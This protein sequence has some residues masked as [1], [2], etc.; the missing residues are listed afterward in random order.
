MSEWVTFQFPWLLPS[1]FKIELGLCLTSRPWL[2]S[3]GRTR[4]TTKG[5]I[6]AWPFKL[7]FGCLLPIVSGVAHEYYDGSSLYDWRMANAYIRIVSTAALTGSTQSCFE[8]YYIPLTMSIWLRLLMWCWCI[9]MDVSC[10]IQFPFP[11]EE[12]PNYFILVVCFS[13]TF[14]S[15]MLLLWLKSKYV[16][17]TEEV[18]LFV[19]QPDP[20]HVIHTDSYKATNSGNMI[21]WATYQAT[22]FHNSKDRSMFHHWNRSSHS[23]LSDLLGVYIFPTWP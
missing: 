5:L 18:F 14:S 22:R 4:L 16:L 21:P 11:T 9:A 10:A 7:V 2:P 6:Y 3:D 13:Q 23:F 17:R 20:W 19:S 1:V 12:K 8:I 15:Q